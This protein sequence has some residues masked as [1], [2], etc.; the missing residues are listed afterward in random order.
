MIEVSWLPSLAGWAGCRHW[1]SAC[2][3]AHAR[4]LTVIKKH[5]IKEPLRG[6]LQGLD[7]NVPVDRL[8]E[9][10]EVAFQF[11]ARAHAHGRRHER[12]QYLSRHCR[13][14]LGEK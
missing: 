2:A 3:D 1:R 12:L 4:S 5:A 14:W 8:C 10:G 6:S 11:V 9:V 7:G 13:E